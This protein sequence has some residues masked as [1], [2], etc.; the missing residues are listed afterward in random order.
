MISLARPHG[1][2]RV[3]EALVR[4]LVTR[5]YGRVRRDPELGPIFE[6]RLAGRWEAHLDTMADFWSAVVLRT[7][8]YGGKPHVAHAGLGLSE[9][10]FARSLQLF[11]ATA[12]QALPADVAALFVD[13]AERIAD[14]LQIG[15]G[16]GPKA[17]R[18]PEAAAPRP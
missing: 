13:R 5:F 14:S 7:G 15:L 18:L 2:D 12:R 1:P 9:R 3:D 8:R 10:H 17:L 6:R 11:Q 4:A 16:I